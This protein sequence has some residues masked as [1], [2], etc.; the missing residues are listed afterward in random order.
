MK[1]FLL[2]SCEHGGNRIP[3][4]CRGP[5]I[6]HEAVLHTH[7]AYDAGALRMAREMAQAFQAPLHAAV[8]SRLLIDLNRSPHH[9]RLYSEFSRHLPQDVRADLL[10]DHY[11]RYR[12]GVEAAV[13][14]AVAA[15]KRVLHVSCHSFTPVLDGKPRNADIGLLYDPSRLGEAAHCRHWR[16]ALLRRMPAL[17]VRMNYPYRGTSDGF[18]VYL[19]KRFGA[20]RYAGIELEINQACV[21]TESAWPALRQALIRSLEDALEHWPDGQP[22]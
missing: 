12:D 13:G 7:R 4:A 2:F 19:R 18:T 14:A 21:R 1:P 15:D 8:L 22:G 10:Q 6:G 17:R 20:D 5:F 11:R 3:S 16:A 9:P